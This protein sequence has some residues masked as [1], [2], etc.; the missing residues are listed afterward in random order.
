[1]GVITISRQIGSSGT[2][3]A[4]HVAKEMGLVVIDKKH[5][6]T[7]KC[8]KT[9]NRSPNLQVQADCWCLFGV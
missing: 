8:P 5:F 3:I 1:M 2:F 6:R 4:E 7:P 9:C